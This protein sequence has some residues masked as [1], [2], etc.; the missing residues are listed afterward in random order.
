MFK[1]SSQITSG[2]YF[3]SPHTFSRPICAVVLFAQFTTFI[4]LAV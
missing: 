4:C 3:Q 1:C 2:I